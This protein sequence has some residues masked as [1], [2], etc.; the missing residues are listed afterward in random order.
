MRS[1][2]FAAATL[3]A[4]SVFSSASA[5]SG[6]DLAQRARAFVDSVSLIETDATAARWDGRICVGAVGLAPDQAQMLIDRI[7]ARAQSVGLRPGEPGCRANVMVIYAPDSDTI[8]RQIVEQRRDLL[9]VNP[10]EVTLGSAALEDFANTPRPIR[11]WHISSLSTGTLRPDATQAIQ[12]AQGSG[13]AR[14]AATG[15]LTGSTMS[16][17]ED[18]QGMDAVRTDG[19]RSRSYERNELSYALIV[20]DARRVAG[21]P[22][23]AWMDYVALVALA[24]LDPYADTGAYPTVLNLFQSDA[25]GATGLTPWDEAFLQSLYRASGGGVRQAADIAR[26]MARQL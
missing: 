2:L 4:F 12:S 11:W 16:T 10:E 26:R 3:A 18:I 13:Q 6:D 7:S 17:A 9:G 19:S 25:S 15:D 8:S 1:A 23:G 22:A 5:Q 14:R 20:V 21:K 24:Q